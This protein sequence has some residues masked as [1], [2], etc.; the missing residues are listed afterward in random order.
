MT[1]RLSF[2]GILLVAVLSAC[3]PQVAPPA[4]ISPPE[5]PVS[6]ALARVTLAGTRWTLVS[7]NGA[8]PK[9]ERAS[10][11]FGSER[12]SM[13]AGCNGIGGN[14]SLVSGRLVGGPYVSTM[15][16]CDGLMDQERAL[17]ALL[18]A[19]PDI[20]LEGDRLIMRSAQYSAIFRRAP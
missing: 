12:L 16:F 5:A 13:T 4:P 6:E 2:S 1:T 9:S 17:G 10:L 20:V 19:R 7:I 14:W 3:I 8:A 18:E 11:A 15:M